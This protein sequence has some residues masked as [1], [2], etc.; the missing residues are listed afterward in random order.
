MEL[1]GARAS[2]GGNERCS[3]PASSETFAQHVTP[4]TGDANT[5]T[6]VVPRTA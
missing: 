1:G 6:R 3:V 2:I 4:G 5:M